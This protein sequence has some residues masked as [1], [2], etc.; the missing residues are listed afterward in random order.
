MIRVLAL[1]WL[2][3]SM[4]PSQA[5]PGLTGFWLTQDRDGVIAVSAC[6]GGLCARIVGVFLDNPADPMPVDYRGVS[7]CNLSLISDA[8]QIQPNL[9]KGHIHDPRNG[10]IYGVELHLDPRG[11]LAVRGFLGVPL[12]GD[13][14]TWTRYKATP[15][16][17]CRIAPTSR[18]F[19]KPGSP[20]QPE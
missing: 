14:Q 18:R 10:K 8:R 5:D 12:L 9:W 4:A 20:K 11:N 17:D 7:Q 19:R 3:L 13:T 1:V 2:L 15:P 16:A 6:D